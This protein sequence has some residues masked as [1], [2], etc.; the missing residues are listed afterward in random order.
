MA[1]IAVSGEPGCRHEEVARMAAERL[2]CEL[3]TESIL[4]QMIAVQFGESRGISDRAWRPLAVSILASLGVDHSHLVV[5]CSGAEML[6]RDLPGVFRFHVMAPERI[7][8]DNLVSDCRLNR[9]E[10]KIRLGKMAAA[11]SQI[12][13]CRFGQ[14]TSP[15]S[16]FDV[17][18]N[19]QAMGAAQMAELLVSAL[20]LQ[21]VLEA[22]PLSA[23]ATAEV[24]F[25]V[26]LQLA[27]YGMLPPDRVRVERKAF[28]HPSEEVFANLLDFYRIAWDYEPRSFPLQ[29][30]KDGKVSEAF[31]PDFYLP[32]FDL[33][34]ELTTMKQAN[35]TKK[36][37]KIRLLRAI[38]PHV[39]IQVFYQKDVQDL[40]MKYRQPERLA[41]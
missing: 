37:R 7:R 24:Q 26:R 15:T 5:S 12:R 20:R 40:V 28:G 3:V 29:W 32:E 1:F 21:G 4:D 16:S 41:R 25:Q 8:L 30:D 22:A 39:N 27:R 17:V 2:G 36:N 38:Y 6:A 23:R 31:T 19:A 35:V 9:A 14:K 11:Q 18:V 10:A 33:Y 13:K 34:V